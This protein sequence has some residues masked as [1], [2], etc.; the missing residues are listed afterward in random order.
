M[1]GNEIA[2]DIVTN[3]KAAD[4]FT[5]ELLPGDIII[6]YV[7]SMNKEP[8]D[9]RPMDC[10]TMSQPRISPYSILKS[11]TSSMTRPTLISPRPSGRQRWLDCLRTFWWVM[12]GWRWLERAKRRDGRRRSSSRP[13]RRVMH[14]KV[15]K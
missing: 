5:A 4:S 11:F 7:G 8:A 12:V 1:Q 3:E 14:S 2:K 6:L 13:G 10:L 15:G 9:L